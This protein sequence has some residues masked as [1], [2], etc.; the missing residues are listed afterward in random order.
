[1]NRYGLQVDLDAKVY[2][3]SVGQKQRVEIIKACIG[4]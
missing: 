4:T 3:L 2:Q 1:M